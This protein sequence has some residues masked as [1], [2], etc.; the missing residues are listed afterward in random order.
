MEFRS[1]IVN[2]DFTDAM[3]KQ[4]VEK[5]IKDTISEKATAQKLLGSIGVNPDYYNLNY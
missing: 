4:V 3:T 5:F 2:G 1:K